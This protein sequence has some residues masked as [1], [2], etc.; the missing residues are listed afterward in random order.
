MSLIHPHIYIYYPYILNAK[1]GV[2]IIVNKI[3]FYFYT[4]ALKLLHFY[5]ST[6]FKFSVEYSYDRNTGNPPTFSSEL[7]LLLMGAVS[8][9]RF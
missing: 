7:Y 4:E 2:V 1:Y 3:Y 6:A 5:H 9:L 8:Y